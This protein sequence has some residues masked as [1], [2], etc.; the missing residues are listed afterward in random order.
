MKLS[1]SGIVDIQDQTVDPLSIRVKPVV[2]ELET[3]YKED[4]QTSADAH[5]KAQDINDCRGLLTGQIP[6]GDLE[7]VTKHGMELSNQ[8]TKKM[9][10]AYCYDNNRLMTLPEQGVVRFRY[11][12]RPLTGISVL[13]R[14]LSAVSGSTWKGRGQFAPEYVFLKC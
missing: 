6:P 3:R 4:D 9:P 5:G 8:R 10:V 7:I 2:A 14:L 13:G 1:F 11:K 12:C